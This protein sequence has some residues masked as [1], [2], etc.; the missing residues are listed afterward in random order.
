MWEVGVWGGEGTGKLNHIVG[1]SSFNKDNALELCA[2]SSP[3]LNPEW[4]VLL[5]GSPVTVEL[6][7]R[8]LGCSVYRKG[9]SLLPG[10]LPVGHRL[11]VGLAVEMWGLGRLLPC[12]TSCGIPWR[13]AGML[14]PKV[15]FPAIHIRVP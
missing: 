15:W 1:D 8:A 13:G 11:L 10:C 5:P 9:H 3:G 4:V 14:L 12:I 6:R 2:I 7:L